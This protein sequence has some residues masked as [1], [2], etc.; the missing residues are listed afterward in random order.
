MNSTV[1]VA[2]SVRAVRSVSSR[3]VWVMAA[4]VATSL[5]A[6]KKDE[7][8]AGATS[9]AALGKSPV[10]KVDDPHFSIVIAPDG[11][12]TAGTECVVKIELD[13]LGGYHV[14]KEYPYKFTATAAKDVEFLGK[15]PAGTSVFTKSAGD[16]TSTSEG[17][18]TMSV[19]FRAKQAGKV[20]VTGTYKFSVCSAQNCQIE[21]A[22]LGAKVDVK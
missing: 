8:S 15:D 1:S 19:H 9:G 16:Y 21:T 20:D 11:L 13:A 5:V 3:L 17:H 12:C 14:N 2:G 18:A 10:S 6:C 22:E 4:L 7:P